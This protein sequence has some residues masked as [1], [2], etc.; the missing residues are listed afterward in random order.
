MQRQT[1]MAKAQEVKRNWYVVDAT[2]IPLGRLASKIAV[3]LMGKNKPT[4][5]PHVDCG[6]NVIVINASKVKLTGDAEHKK[7]YYNVSE[8]NGG[9]RTRSSGVMLREFPVEMIE[10]AV[11]G[12]LPKGRLGRSISK[13]LFVYADEKHE[14]EAQ[15]PVVL[16]LSK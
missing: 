9:L 13:K 1:T 6:D 12:M 15:K 10:R 7:N 8:Y 11:W 14:Q 5:T 2:N 16:D 4:Y 3:I